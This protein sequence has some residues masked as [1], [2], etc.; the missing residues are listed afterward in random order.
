MKEDRIIYLGQLLD[1]FDEKERQNIEEKIN[2]CMKSIC[3]EDVAWVDF[4][5]YMSSKEKMQKLLKNEAIEYLE[6][7]ADE[8]RLGNYKD[9]RISVVRVRSR[10]KREVST[11]THNRH[12]LI[13]TIYADNIDLMEE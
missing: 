13:A 9:I 6:V 5:V 8:A 2:D 7:I 12:T 4:E 11:I 3:C 1:D 10:K